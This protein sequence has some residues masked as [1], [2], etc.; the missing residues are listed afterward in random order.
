MISG[1]RVVMIKRKVITALLICS[2]LMLTCA[3][4]IYLSDNGKLELGTIGACYR[5]TVYLNYHPYMENIGE[6]HIGGTVSMP[7]CDTSELG[8]AIYNKKEHIKKITDYLNAVPLVK[9]SEDELPNKSPDSYIQYFDDK[10]ALINNF[11]IYGQIFLKDVNNNKLY[12]I[13]EYDSG[14]IEGLEKLNFT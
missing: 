6:I 1:K 8:K 5:E 10:G 4:Y 9:A 3:L 12:R 14:L 7:F 11:I 2:I 13:K